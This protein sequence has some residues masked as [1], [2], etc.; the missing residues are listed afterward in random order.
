MTKSAWALPSDAQQNIKQFFYRG[1]D[2]GIGRIG[3]LQHD[4][5]RHLVV[6]VDARFAAVF[7]LKRI[8]DDLLGRRVACRIGRLRRLDRNDPPR[9]AVDGAAERRRGVADARRRGIGAAR[10]RQARK[11]IAR[12]RIVADIGFRGRAVDDE[13]CVVGQDR[14]IDRDAARKAVDLRRN[15]EAARIGFLT[16]SIDKERHA[17]ASIRERGRRDRGADGI[18][19]G[20]ARAAIVEELDRV[21]GGGSLGFDVAVLESGK[22]AGSITLTMVTLC[23]VPAGVSV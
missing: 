8:R 6:D 3:V 4:E 18:D 21:A 13:R 9:K 15:V 16:R 22:A 2:T 12:P 11:Q 7:I 19:V 5:V 17:G 1:D 23:T 20:C 14:G 10:I